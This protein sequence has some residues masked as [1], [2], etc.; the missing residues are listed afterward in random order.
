MIFKIEKCD[1]YME[2]IVI[3][4]K[5]YVKLKVIKNMK[6]VMYV[7]YRNLVEKKYM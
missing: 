5:Y 3:D 1:E 4:V 6:Y 2:L 7:I